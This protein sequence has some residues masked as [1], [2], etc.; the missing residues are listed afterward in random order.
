MRSGNRG[1]NT[2]PG[3]FVRHF[4]HAIG[5]R[6]RLHSTQLPGRPDI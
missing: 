5:C 1:T 2:K 6:Y 3:K 4:L